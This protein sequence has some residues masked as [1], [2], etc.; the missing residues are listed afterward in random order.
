MES[1]RV[2]VPNLARGGRALARTSDA[3]FKTVF[4]IAL[5]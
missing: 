1:V 5:K 3:S 4:S 2:Q